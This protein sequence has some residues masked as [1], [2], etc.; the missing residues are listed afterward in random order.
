MSHMGD[1]DGDGQ[2]RDEPAAARLVNHSHGPV[3]EAKRPR[4]NPRPLQLLQSREYSNLLW[5][6]TEPWNV[7]FRYIIITLLPSYLIPLDSLNHSGAGGYR[8]EY[9]QTSNGDHHWGRQFGTWGESNTLR[10]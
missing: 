4:T 5:Y 6:S 10:V 2:D 8:R 3:S 9:R 7:Y 1:E